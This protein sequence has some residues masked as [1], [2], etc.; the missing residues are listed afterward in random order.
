MISQNQF[1]RAQIGILLSLLVPL[2]FLFQY[3]RPGTPD[4]SMSLQWLFLLGLL[5]RILCIPLARSVGVSLL[6]VLS[7]CCEAGF[8]SLFLSNIIFFENFRSVSLFIYPLLFVLLLLSVLFFLNSLSRIARKLER[9]D[10]PKAISFIL[11]LTVLTTMSYLTLSFVGWHQ[12]LS[13][14]SYLGWRSIVILYCLTLFRFFLDF[15]RRAGQPAIEKR[16]NTLED[17]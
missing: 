13:W 1:R 5:G 15:H 11:T 6:L 7:V 14:V 17:L 2:F 8:Y 16:A 3:F 10:L 4:Y 9:Q 12:P